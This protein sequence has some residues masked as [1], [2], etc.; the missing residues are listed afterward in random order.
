MKARHLFVSLGLF[1]RRCLAQ[2]VSVTR[3]R[4]FLSGNSNAKGIRFIVWSGA[5]SLA[6]LGRWSAVAG[7]LCI[8]ALCL[9]TRALSEN[10]VSDSDLFQTPDWTAQ[11]IG[12]NSPAAV[13]ALGQ[14]AP[15]PMLRKEFSVNRS[16]VKATLRICGLGF[17]EAYLNGRRVGDQVLDPPPT[18][19]NETALYATF[20]VSDIVHPGANAIGVTLGRGYFGAT[21]DDGFNLGSAP[22]RS[23]PRLL[24]QLDITY[25]DGETARVVSDGSWEMA[26]SPILDS[27]TFGEHYDARLEQP[28]WTLPAF[29]ASTWMPCA[30]TTFADKEAS[31]K[32]NEAH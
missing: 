10:D 13:P 3:S 17:Y 20:D 12:R 7:C 6:G 23:E 5:P 29:D 11:W 1:A 24:L 21:A 2:I 26:D 32:G 4:S 14:Q 27:M 31:P 8:S 28:G 30:G 22:W 18:V 19:Y 25:R 16:V 15:A 9:P